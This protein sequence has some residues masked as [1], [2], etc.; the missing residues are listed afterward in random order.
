MVIA[1]KIR[2]SSRIRQMRLLD[3]YASSCGLVIKTFRVLVND[4]KVTSIFRAA[5]ITTLD[6]TV[7]CYFVISL[8]SVNFRFYGL[9]SLVIK[10][11]NRSIWNLCFSVVLASSNVSSNP[12]TDSMKLFEFKDKSPRFAP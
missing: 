4:R 2:S 9:R 11:L 8:P 5:K 7:H 6:G 10:L 3:S 12:K 1:C